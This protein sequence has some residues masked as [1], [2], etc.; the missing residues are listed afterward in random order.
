MNVAT[1]LAISSSHALEKYNYSRD[2]KFFEYYVLRFSLFMTICMF[3]AKYNAAL[4]LTV[5]LN[6]SC[7]N[8]SLKIVGRQPKDTLIPPPPR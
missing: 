7:N 3:V 5:L 4:C 8:L 1:Y 6:I 2:E